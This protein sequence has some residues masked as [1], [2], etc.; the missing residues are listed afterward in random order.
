MDTKKHRLQFDLTVEALD[1]L[2][3]LKEQAR[4]LTRAEVVRNALRLYSWFLNQRAQGKEVLVRTGD[5][6]E[7]IEL[8]FL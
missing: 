7:K 4:A 8:M 2:D 3:E 6:I 1:Q 5:E